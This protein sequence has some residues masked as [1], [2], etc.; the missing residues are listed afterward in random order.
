MFKFY[1]NARFFMK[2]I[3]VSYGSNPTNDEIEAFTSF[4]LDLIH[5]HL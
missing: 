1:I 3:C 4:S 2:I 5:E